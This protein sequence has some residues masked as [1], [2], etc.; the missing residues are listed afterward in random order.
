LF[1]TTLDKQAQSGLGFF[2]HTVTD[3]ES[4][5]AQLELQYVVRAWLASD[6]ATLTAIHNKNL[7]QF[8]F[9]YNPIT[10]QRNR[11][12]VTT[13]RAMMADST[14]TLFIVGSL[15][16]I[17]PGSFIDQLGSVGL[18]SRHLTAAR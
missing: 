18:R 6:L 2:E 1:A 15:H 10:I 7:L 8:P 13:A 17:G 16:T 14:P 9:I 3:A 5:A 12:W 11:E 4:G